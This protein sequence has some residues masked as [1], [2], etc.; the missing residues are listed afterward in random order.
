MKGWVGESERGIGPEVPEFMEYDRERQ[1]HRAAAD[2]G[3]VRK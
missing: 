3:L 1:R 2:R